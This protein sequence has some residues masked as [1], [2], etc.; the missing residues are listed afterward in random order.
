MGRWD[1]LDGGGKKPDAGRGHPMTAAT[2]AALLAW[3]QAIG[4]DDR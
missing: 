4:G 3:E 1:N 2:I